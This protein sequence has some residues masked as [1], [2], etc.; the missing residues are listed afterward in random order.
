MY[1]LGDDASWYKV[2]KTDAVTREIS[3]IETG[4]KDIYPYRAFMQFTQSEAPNNMQMRLVDEDIPTGVTD[5]EMT[6]EE[7]DNIIYD[8]QG[9]RVMEPQKGNLYIINTKKVLF[10]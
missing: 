10:K 7:M 3:N 8:L 4:K 5:V 1:V 9:R 6:E 2:A